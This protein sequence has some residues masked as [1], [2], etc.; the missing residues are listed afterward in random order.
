MGGPVSVGGMGRRAFETSMSAAAALIAVPLLVAGAL[1]IWAN[2]FVDSNVH[3]KL[4][5]QRSSSLP[6]AAWRSLLPPRSPRS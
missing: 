5:A 4:A 1:L 3:W 2:S 6:R